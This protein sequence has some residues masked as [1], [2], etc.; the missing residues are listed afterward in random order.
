MPKNI[1]K[2]PILTGEDAKNF[3]NSEKIYNK[4][5]ITLI[6]KIKDKFKK[7]NGAR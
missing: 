5:L 7:T 1:R 3:I 4:I 6:E 2:R